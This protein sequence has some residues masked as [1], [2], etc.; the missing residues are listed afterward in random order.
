[1]PVLLFDSRSTISGTNLCV[2]TWHVLCSAQPTPTESNAILATLKTFF[3]ALAAY[4]AVGSTVV[5]GTRVLYFDQA[6]WQKPTFDANGKLLTKG[7]FTTE[8][9]IVGATPNT[10]IAGTGGT[11]LPGQLAACLS[12]RTSVSG[13][14][15]RGRSYLGNWG[16][17]AMTGSG[18]TAGCVGAVNSGAGTLLTNITAVTGTDGPFYLSVW[19]P[20]KGVI[21]PILT[22]ATDSVFDTMRSRVK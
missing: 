18:V 8:P 21:R 22:G 12:W 20:T 7:K 2:N 17:A 6:W 13:R 4:R 5:T 16:S 15:G 19:S 11:P 1:M 14:S 3:D 9:I 10:S